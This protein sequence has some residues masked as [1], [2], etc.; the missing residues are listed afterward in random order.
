MFAVL[1]ALWMGAMTSAQ[2]QSYEAKAEVEDLMSNFVSAANSRIGDM[3]EAGGPQND[4]DWENSASAARALADISQVL[5]MVGRVKDRTWAEGAQAM[6][7]AAEALATASTAKNMEQ[8]NA[9][10]GQL[11]QTCRT[12]HEVHR[13]RRQRG[14]GRGGQ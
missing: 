11:G 8:W 6:G 12:C 5:L 7:P 2:A 4:E 9:A 1:A 10:R 3:N 14:G 13:P